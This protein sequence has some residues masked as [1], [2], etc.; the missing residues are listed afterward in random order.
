LSC[1]ELLRHHSWPVG[2]AFLSVCD[3]RFASRCQAPAIRRSK[4]LS[5]SFEANF[6]SRR[7]SAPYSLY[8]S[9]SIGSPLTSN[10]FGLPGASSEHRKTR[11]GK[12]TASPD[13]RE[14]IRLRIVYVAS[15]NPL[16]GPPN[17]SARIKPP[18]SEY[19]LQRGAG[20]AGRDGI[21][22]QRH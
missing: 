17:S 10:M 3:S 12:Q 21:L 5:L 4:S 1:P 19:P 9:D 22:V 6:A 14:I 20:L 11:Q 8:R 18:R 16:P 13:H 7:H 15:A 2:E